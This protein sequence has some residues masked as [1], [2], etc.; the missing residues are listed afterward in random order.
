MSIRDPSAEADF[1]TLV[2]VLRWRARHQHERVA[3]TFIGDGDEQEVS[4]TYG[5]LDRRARAIAGA[6]V[7]QNVVAQPVL[8][9]YPSGLEFIAAFFGALYAGAIAVP[10]YPPRRNRRDERLSAVV[11]NSGARVLLTTAEVHAEQAHFLRQTTALSTLTW[12]VTDAVSDTAGDGWQE[13]SWQLQDIAFL[14]YTSGSTSTPKGVMVSH[15]NLIANQRLI[16]KGFG[17]NERSII[18]SWLPLFHDMGLVGTTLNPLYGGFRCVFMSP[19]LFLQRP[20]RWL[21]AISR[22]KGTSSGGPNFAYDLCVSRTTPEERQGLDLSS[23]EVAFNGAEPVRADTLNRFAEAFAPH[24]FRRSAFLPCYGM[25]ETT[26][27]VGAGS[28]RQRPLILNLDST[29][30]T[31]DQVRVVDDGAPG[32]YASV[33]CGRLADDEQLVIVDPEARR[34]CAEARI[35]EIWIS[36]DSVAQGYWNLTQETQETFQARLEGSDTLFLRTGDRGFLADG[37]LH[38]TGRL[39]DVIIV[40]GRNYYPQDIEKTVEECHPAI[41]YSGGAAFAHDGDGEER[42]AIAFE[43]ERKYVRQLDAEEIFHAIQRHVFQQ[44]EL[45]PWALYLLKPGAI[46]KTSSGKIRRRACKEGIARG[47]LEILAEWRQG[48]QQQTH[49]AAISAPSPV[50]AAAAVPASVIQDWLTAKLAESLKLDIGRVDVRRPFADYGLDSATAVRLSGELEQRLQRRLPPTLLYDHPTIETLARQLGASDPAPVVPLQTSPGAGVATDAIAI[51]GI[52]CRFP[53]ADG[54]RQFWQL[55]RQGIDSVSEVPADR[56]NVDEFFDA[57]ALTPGKMN[58]RWGGFL[59]DVDRF[60]ESFFGIAPRE[61]RCMDPQQRILLETAYEAL[62]DAGIPATSLNGTRTGVYIGICNHDYSSLSHANDDLLDPRW[63]TGNALSIAANR[64]SYVF[65]LKGPSLAIDTACS[66]SLVAVHLACRSLAN[67]E[68]TLALAGGVNLILKPDVTVS[69][70]GAGGT[71]PDGRCKAFDA[72]ANGMVR[73]DGVGVVVLKPLAQAQADGDPIYAVIVGSAVNHDGLSN[74]ITAPNQSSQEAVLREAYMRARRAPERVQYIEAHGTG[75]LLGDPIEANAL[76]N[77]LTAN[78]P[79]NRPCAIGSVKSNIGHTEAAAGVA[80]LIKVALALRHGELPASLH[81]RTPNPHVPFDQLQLRVQQ[82]LSAWPD[83]GEPRLAGVSAFGFGGTNAHIVVEAAPATPTADVASMATQ[84]LPISAHSPEALTDLV[85]GYQ[86]WLQ[87][88]L[89]AATLTDLCYTAAVHRDHHDH[90]L[91]IVFKTVDE[92]KDRLQAFLSGE[93]LAGMAHS[94]KATSVRPRIAFVFSGHR[95]QRFNL[96]RQFLNSEPVFADVIGRCEKMFRRYAGWSLIEQLTEGQLSPQQVDIYHPCQFAYQVALARLWQSFGVEPVAVVGHSFGEVAASHVAGALSLEDA[97]KV[98]F[99]RSRFLQQAAAGVSEAGAMATVELP[100]AEMQSILDQRA[101]GV[102]ISVNNSPTSVVLSGGASALAELVQWLKQRQ[103]FCNL[104]DTPGAG[105]SKKI[106]SADFMR[107]LEGIRPRPTEV[108]LVSSVFGRVVDGLELDAVYWA[109]NMKDPVL[110][111]DAVNQLVD[112]GCDTYLEIA[113]YPP[114]LAHAVAQCVRY[115]KQRARTLPLLRRNAD[116]QVHVYG[117]LAELYAAGH[118]VR[119]KKLYSKPGARLPLPLYPWQRKRFWIDVAHDRA[120]VATKTGD[121]P[122]LRQ[123]LQPASEPR[124]CFWEMSLSVAS[125]PYIA[126]HKVQGAI[127]FPTTAYVEMALAAAK[128]V[129][130]D[131]PCTLENLAIDK[132]LFLAETGVRTLQVILTRA[133]ENSAAIEFHSRAEGMAPVAAWL[134]H[135]TVSLKYHGANVVRVASDFSPAA[136]SQYPDRISHG[137]HYRALRERGVDYGPAFQGVQNL[138]RRDAETLGQV[139]L[140]ATETSDAYLW[141]PALLD[142]C[143][144]VLAGPLHVQGGTFSARDLYLPVGVGALTVYQLPRAGATLWSRASLRST[145]DIDR[146]TG[147]VIVS[148]GAGNT[149]AEISGFVL[150]RVGRGRAAAYQDPDAW[151]YA[152]QW[153]QQ[154]RVPALTM[155]STREWIVFAD[156]VVG[157][158]L[159]D[160]LRRRQAQC[161][162]VTRGRTFARIS[163]QHFEIDPTQ[164]GDYERLIQAIAGPGQRHCAIVHLWSLQTP[165]DADAATPWEAAT[166]TGCITVSRL[167][168]ALTG[169]AGPPPT[170]LFL[171]TRGAQPVDRQVPVAAQAMIWGLGKVIAIE[172]PELQCAL[173]D[174]AADAAEG[175]VGTLLDELAVADVG[176]RQVALRRHGRYEPRL[177]RLPLTS[178]PPARRVNG[179]DSTVVHDA[180][181]YLVAGGLGGIGLRIAQ[182]LCQRGA[183]HLVLLGRSGAT[184]AAAEAVTALTA[185]GV[186]VHVARTDV[187]DETA[188]AAVLAHVAGTMPPL[189]G[190]IHA[191]A[192]VDPGLLKNL[193]DDRFKAVMAPKVDGAWN[194]HRLTAKL[195]LD[196]FVLFSSVASLL[197]TPGQANYV[198][199]NAYLDG[200]A[201]QRRALGLPALSI[202]WGGWSEVGMVARHASATDVFALRGFATLTP[203]QGLATLERLLCHDLPQVAAMAVNWA[204]VCDVYPQMAQRPFLAELM[205]AAAPRGKGASTVDSVTRSDLLS[206]PATER[207][208]RLRVYLG[209]QLARTLGTSVAEIDVDFP[210]NAMGIDSLM[211]LEMKNRVEAELGAVLP[212]VKLLEG[213]NIRQIA[214]LLLAE[215]T[216]TT[217]NAAPASMAGAPAADTT[218]DGAKA[219]QLLTEVEHL[220]DA[221]VEALLESLESTEEGA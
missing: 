79:P 179:D 189:R 31:F 134:R 156:D 204:Q 37:E 182:W 152:V 19:L 184:G 146:V 74:G 8:L 82:Q 17:H 140:P 108:P 61:A 217:S 135:A 147:D 86:E 133:S 150:E 202:N 11:E 78:R 192:V 118:P 219:A 109:R 62:Q 214:E 40:R 80:S 191:A 24:G 111:A 220:S 115:R 166:N 188:L 102:S 28:R 22:H 206:L 66:S 87:H 162:V 73:S 107:D 10:L 65:N 60:D 90:R 180:A 6:L 210:I 132:A 95:G 100:R 101:P 3:Y 34:P 27:L 144:Q 75:T 130:G 129:F 186:Q 120:P 104:L 197:G 57:R 93:A 112:R 174:L 123:G 187:A 50:A 52:G 103:V 121:H 92:L 218:I 44:H 183:R 199:A 119:W 170:E 88:S 67:G 122:L 198:V 209:A 125:F 69:F 178:L 76:A 196:F 83:G 77:V 124:L 68:A 18:V 4:M 208:E 45:R 139:Q 216:G 177:Q 149:V 72:G 163:A 54:P 99:V 190:V 159:A 201:H 16:V 7:E 145:T 33:G 105:H 13:R 142:A 14:Q 172:H 32:A 200:L 94:E 35:G 207:L 194:L 215:I 193:S 2:H 20:I 151:L 47:D 39:K 46:P 161:I 114:V 137:Q 157:P 70:S 128:K 42:L 38:I 154:A 126:D 5:E 211:A 41:R 127:I 59:R 110:F 171:V 176:A 43:V 131:G 48:K 116:E 117:A 136:I 81:Y 113:P 141:H 106:A 58:T 138:W 89:P 49:G 64:L 91:A 1:P 143:L 51:V 96:T 165:A 173:I 21:Q 53:G 15:G 23:W 195:P 212:I 203:E 221:E 36:G 160:E 213:A 205:R 97:T 169:R 63:T 98:I 168:Q 155:A 84:L 85:R 26:L 12:V 56:W 181:T 148:D 29:A 153:R 55:L 71:S 30:L 175:D 167:V 164:A 158:A 25:A 9:L 185:Q